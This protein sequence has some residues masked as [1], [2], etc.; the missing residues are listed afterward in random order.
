[1]AFERQQREDQIIRIENQL[2]LVATRVDPA[3]IQQKISSLAE[4]VKVSNGHE[5]EY[6]ALCEGM[7]NTDK[8]RVRSIMLKHRSRLPTSCN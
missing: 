8:R 4:A 3:P 7:T 6:N 2:K 1:V 5:E